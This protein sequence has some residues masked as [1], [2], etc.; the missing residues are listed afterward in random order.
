M[1]APRIFLNLPAFEQPDELLGMTIE[2]TEQQQHHLSKVLR[3]QRD[4]EVM[5]VDPGTEVEFVGRLQLSSKDCSVELLRFSGQGGVRSVVQTLVQGLAKGERND[6]IVQ[7]VVELGVSRVFLFE[8]E[9]SVV[10]LASE[11]ERR[12][13]VQRFE[14]II[15]SAA[16]QSAKRFLCEVKVLASLS[17]AISLLGSVRDRGDRLLLA[18]LGC[19]AR[20]IKGCTPWSHKAHLIIG[21][22][23]DLSLKEQEQAISFGFVPMTLGPHVLRTETAAIAGVAMLDAL[24]APEVD[25][26]SDR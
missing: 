10:R 26:R 6:L 7:K 3:R 17:E 11:K 19:A 21:P 9:H 5:V 15:E 22:E 16:E 12:A 8:G 20:S 14:K 13:K 2:L 1:S 23:G 18:S 24:A 25:L 4:S